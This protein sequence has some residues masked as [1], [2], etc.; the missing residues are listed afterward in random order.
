MEIA[1]TMLLLASGGMIYNYMYRKKMYR[2]I[3]RLEAW[4]IAI[5]NRQV[6]EELS[7]VK[8]LNMTGETEQ[9]FERWRQQWDDI[10][11]IRLPEIEEKL[12]DV[13]EFLD[14]YRYAKAKAVL[15]EIEQALRKIEED[16]Q[17]I[18]H[19]L[20]ELVGSEEQN[21]TEI[22]QLKT[23]YR[24]AKKT[25]LAYRHTFGEAEENLAR[26]LEEIQQGFQR[27]EELTNDGNYLAARE[28][29]FVLKQQL[30]DVS[31]MLQEIPAL[32]TEC[33]TAVPAQLSELVEGYQEMKEAGY[34]LDH[35]DIEQEIA[36]QQEKLPQCLDMIRTLELEEAKRL[37]EE[38][39]SDIDALYDL[40]EKE[41]LA[42]QYVKTEMGQL[43]EQLEQL[44]EEAKQ[45]G[46]ETLFVQQSYRLS[47]K[48]LEKYRSIEK[49]IQ[50][51]AKRFVF[52]QA[53]ALEERTAHSLIKEEL[54]SLAGQMQLLKE[55]HEQFREM[56]QTLRKDEL[57]AREKLR[58]MRHQLSEAV[59]Y[60]KKSRL[61]GLPETYKLQLDEAK[62][63]LTTVSLRLDE[64]PLNMEAVQQA[65]AAAAALVERVSEQ[66]I[67]M[68][69]QADLVEKVIQY[70]N[71]YRRRYS[72]VKEG[73]E[74][75]E[76]L[77]RQYEYEQAL[78]QAVATVEAVEPG[79]FERVRQLLQE[80]VPK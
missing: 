9:L 47:T 60:V 30:T 11:T 21:R 73:L 37:L 64:K 71:R 10:V 36:K 12:F 3:D 58:E 44:D 27:F 19:E 2:E 59:R 32:L 76:Q 75:A 49:Q 68:V 51:L 72:S 6:T 13:E 4:K 16:I 55:E 22:E 61:P 28:A 8:Q 42:Y 33:Q 17:T 23:L 34:I 38:I 52:I 20:D 26:K 78:E 39:K 7:K 45:T 69:E 15:R 67:S 79:A 46:A 43:Q 40:L 63:L 56:L 48:D 5:M 54:E 41:V 50:Q 18:L 65:L 66:T 25:L 57:A 80:E 14:K 35:L 74:E 31:N 70:G 62:D 29:V 24:E 77:F 53:R 1:V